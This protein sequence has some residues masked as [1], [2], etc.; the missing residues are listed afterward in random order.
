[1][2]LRPIVQDTLFPTVC[3]V[4]GPNELAYLGQLAAS[5]S[6]R[7]ADAADVP[8]RVGHDRRLRGA[9]LSHKYELPLEALQP[10]DEAALNELLRRRFHRPS[11]TRFGDAT[12]RNRR[13]DD[14]R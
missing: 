12:Q 5:T 6:I 8:A 11:K 14:A 4:A 10:Q 9:P 2:L 1:M 7:R 13:A 3:Y